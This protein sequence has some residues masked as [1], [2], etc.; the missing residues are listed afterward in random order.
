MGVW[1][2]CEWWTRCVA[3]YVRGSVCMVECRGFS[4]GGVDGSKV[5]V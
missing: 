2:V 5:H 1:G 3:A 4:E